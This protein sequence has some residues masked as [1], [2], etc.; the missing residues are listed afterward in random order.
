MTAAEAIRAGD[1]AALEA[2]LQADAGLAN[3]RIDGSR[4][5]LHAATDW[6]GHFPNVAQSIALLIAHGAD[7]NARFAGGRHTETPLHWA[8]STNDID[9]LNALIE[10]GANIEAD[11]AVIGAGTPMADAVAFAQWRC[12]RRLLECGAQT[13]LWQA[14]ALGLADRVESLLADQPSPDEI[15]KAFWCAC[16]GGQRATAET[17]LARGADR[18]WIG[19]DH[20][21]PA[22]AAR[23]NGFHDVAEWLS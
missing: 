17:L 13:N 12:A 20:L 2:L 1:T 3:A 7:V 4:T 18:H 14:A 9:A 15:T 11:G 5:L 16:H 22:A 8:A 23:R 19:Y 6:P 10:A 21:T